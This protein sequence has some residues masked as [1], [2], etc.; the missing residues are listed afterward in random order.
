MSAALVLPKF[1]ANPADGPMAADRALPS[2]L[3]LRL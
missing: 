2:P 1:P 3:E